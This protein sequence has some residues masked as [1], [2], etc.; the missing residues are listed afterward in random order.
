MPFLDGINKI[1]GIQWGSSYGWDIRFPDAPRPF[2]DFFPASTLTEND[3]PLE[4]YVLDMYMGQQKI[5]QKSS[6]GSINIT[7]F[8]NDTLSLYKWIKYWKEVEILNNGEYVST[9]EKCVKRVF[10]NKINSKQEV[11]DRLAYIVYP[12]GSLEYPGNSESSAIEFS[13][14]FTIVGKISSTG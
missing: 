2:N 13:C 7:F 3:S 4:S 14:E 9:L 10:I 6:A 8:D 5:P 11:V 12:E 1:R